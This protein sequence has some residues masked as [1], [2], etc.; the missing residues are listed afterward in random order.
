MVSSGTAR[1][2]GARVRRAQQDPLVVRIVLIAT[3]MLAVGGLV[4]VPTLFVFVQALRPGL[5]AYFGHLISDPDTWSAITLTLTV[6][7]TA[8]ILNVIF[9]VAAAWLIARFRFPGRTILTTLIDLPFSVSPVVAGLMFVLI[10]GLQG[11][12]GPWL[13]ADGMR[14]MLYLLAGTGGLLAFGVSMVVLKQRTPMR[15][16]RLAA[17]LAIGT[18]TYVALVAL[19]EVLDLWPHG[20]SLNIIFATPGLVLAT[21]FVTFPFVA[22]ELIPVMEAFGE[23]E[24]L[25][26]VSLG[27][28]GWQMFW[29]VTLPNIKWGLLYGVILCNAR[30][31]GEFGAVYVVSGHIAGKT[32]TMPLRVEKLYQEYNLPGAY[33]VASLLTLLAL[34]TLVLK[35]VVERRVTQKVIADGSQE[36]ES[37]V[38]HGH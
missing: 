18:L 27:A 10:F 30:A 36:L 19:Q 2:D 29:R 23:E 21:T 15:P 5:S 3:A 24:D 11:H 32:D 7:P 13:R 34:V 38:P 9:G 22:R 12:L 17:A 33:A 20:H 35:V 37:T 4:V 1:S 16:P 25:A 31:M 26:A 8:V 28:T 6:A 14:A